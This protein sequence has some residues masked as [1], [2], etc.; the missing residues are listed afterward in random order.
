MHYFLKPHVFKK[1]HFLI[2]PNFIL[3]FSQIILI[4]LEILP[5]ISPTFSIE[6]L[7]T[8]GAIKKNYVPILKAENF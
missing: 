3:Y 7:A 5:N 2:S 1:V 4:D 8:I 6:K